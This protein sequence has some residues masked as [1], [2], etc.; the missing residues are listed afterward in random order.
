MKWLLRILAAGLLLAALV[1]GAAWQWIERPM[2]LQGERA[3]VSIEAGMTP[4]EIAQ[5]WVSAGV[6]VPPEWLYQWFRWSGEARRIRAGSY[7]I[8]S[9]TSP[10]ALLDKMVRGAQSLEQLRLI[11]G[12]SFSQVRLALA[13]APGLRPTL[14][15]LSDAEAA[16]AL[17]MAEGASIEG[18]LFPDTYSYSKGVS[19]L[20]VLQ[21][22]HAAMQRRL[23]EVWDGRAQPTP[24]QTPQDLLVLASVIEKE[25]G[26]ASDRGQIAGV[27]I[28]RLRI[29]MPLQSDPTVIYGMGPR[30]DGNLRR[31]DL[32]TDNAWNTYT[33][34]G[35]PATP[36]ALPGLAALRAAAR[37]EA[38][39]A[40]Y[41]VAR[42]DGSSAFSSN[43]SDHNRAVNQF[44][45]GN[46]R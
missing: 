18:W 33:R 2:P 28:N 34:R 45:R 40:L 23:A 32:Q 11:E 15:N 24:L 46:S 17:G 4:R 37:P 35:L 1:A 20:T 16:R 43:L 36:I 30:F 39:T 42:G 44:Q 31:S 26:Q 3:E 6:D 22:A 13:K 19:D 10:R 7:E 27:F 8:E 12:W 29:G 38:T 41:F 21:R 5:Q 25:T 9:G 14:Q